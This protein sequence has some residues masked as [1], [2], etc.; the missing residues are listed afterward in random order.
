MAKDWSWDERKRKCPVI[1][2]GCSSFLKADPGS[3]NLIPSLCPATSLQAQLPLSSHDFSPLLPFFPGVP[4]PMYLCPLH[5]A[6]SLRSLPKHPL[7]GFVQMLK[8][9]AGFATSKPKPQTCSLTP[10]LFIFSTAEAHPQNRNIKPFG[11]RSA[12]KESLRRER[13]ERQVEWRGCLL[14]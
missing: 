7:K 11:T 14:R 12:S 4:P 9:S 3:F 8:R 10:F 6:F 5:F 13:N 1:H 2:F